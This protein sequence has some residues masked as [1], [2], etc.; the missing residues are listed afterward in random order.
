VFAWF[1]TFEDR[2]SDGARLGSAETARLVQLLKATRGL[3]RGL[4]FTPEHTRDPYADDGPSPG[5]ALELYFAE[6]GAL[7]AA[8][9][10]HGDLQALATSDVLSSFEHAAATQQAMAARSFPVPDPHF[11]NAPGE[12][13]CTYL[14]HYPGK[15]DDLN[16]W[17]SYIVHHPPVMAR[18][19]GIREIEICTR[20]DWCGFLPWPRVEYMQRNKVVF[21]SAQA[22]T[23]ALNSPVREEMRAD[24]AKFPRFTGGSRHYA[25]AT[26]TVR[27]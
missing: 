14:V 12:L 17:L 7:E 4:I 1:L 22:L 9:G 6:L 15:A 24:F 23:S 10:R 16:E 3:V 8:L 26:L 19:P 25:L 18:F 11:A 2:V 13:P 5:L 21:D 20:L 27:P